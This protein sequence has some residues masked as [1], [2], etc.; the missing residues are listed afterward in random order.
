MNSNCVGDGRQSVSR[1]GERL[2]G[3]SKGTGFVFQEPTAEALLQAVQA[4][5][6]TYANRTAWQ[7][8]I[9]NAMAQDVSWE[10][11]AKPYLDLYQRSLRN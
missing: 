6:T 1:L 2:G 7:Q 3:W 10:P 5:L 8:L 11:S 9:R 4:A